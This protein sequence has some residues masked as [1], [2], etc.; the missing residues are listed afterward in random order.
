MMPPTA[1][2][3]LGLPVSGHSGAAFSVNV[4]IDSPNYPTADTKLKKITIGS[5]RFVCLS[6]R[7]LTGAVPVPGCP[8]LI[9]TVLPLIGGS[10]VTSR[11]T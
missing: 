3:S 11:Y 9:G 5:G 2:L 6:A 10:G 1:F 4:S 8:L 7:S